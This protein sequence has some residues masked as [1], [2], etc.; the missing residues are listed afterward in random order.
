MTDIKKTITFTSSVD[1]RK[2]D[3]TI[4]FK[5]EAGET[6]TLSAPSANRWLRRNKAVPGKAEIKPAA[7]EKA[8]KPETME[9]QAP[10]TA[11]DNNKK[12]A[13]AKTTKSKKQG[14]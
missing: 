8:E 6:V 12:N 10:I 13:P 2:H 4:E 11:P 9:K 7:A 14:G 5:A 1:V 3:G